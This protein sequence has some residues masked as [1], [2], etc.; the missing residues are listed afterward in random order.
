MQTKQLSYLSSLSSNFK[1]SIYC[2][3]FF[4]Q[5]GCFFPKIA[6]WFQGHD[7]HFGGLLHPEPCNVHRAS[8]PR[9]HFV[10]SIEDI[11]LVWPYLTLKN[12]LELILDIFVNPKNMDF[13]WEIV[14]FPW[15]I[16]NFPWEIGKNPKDPSASLAEDLV[17]LLWHTD[18]PG[19]H[20]AA[21]TQ[22]INMWDSIVRPEKNHG[23]PSNQKGRDP[24]CVQVW[25][26]AGLARKT[27][28]WSDG[29]GL[30][31]HW[32]LVLLHLRDEHLHWRHQ[33]AI[34]KGEGTGRWDVPKLT[35]TLAK[36]WLV[37]G[38]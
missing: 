4:L 34:F 33:W 36:F 31:L 10:Q 35:G 3:V 28:T 1:A 16:V 5:T 11:I 25:L 37:G 14:N 29:V 20:T 23:R 7:L 27:S 32:G 15:E 8:D 13:P 9:L 30:A 6:L 38:A 22:Y 26:V 17:E 12:I 21:Y 2:T 24:R 18:H 19:L